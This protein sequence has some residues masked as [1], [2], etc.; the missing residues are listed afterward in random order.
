[1]SFALNASRRSGSFLPGP[2]RHSEMRSSC[3]EEAPFSNPMI[4]FER[5]F[6]CD[7]E[8]SGSAS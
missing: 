7:C 2:H 8:I 4:C 1:M 6:S 5:A 3:S